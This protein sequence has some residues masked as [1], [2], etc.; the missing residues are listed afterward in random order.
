MVS[1]AMSLS[2]MA[3]KALPTLVFMR[4]RAAMISRKAM[5]TMRKY[6]FRSLFTTKDP[7]VRGGASMPIRPPKISQRPMTWVMAMPKPNVAMAR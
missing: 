4:L 2:L 5:A 6:I 1:A 3:M 7:K